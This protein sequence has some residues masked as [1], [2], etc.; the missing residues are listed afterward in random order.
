M[1]EYELTGNE[2]ALFWVLSALFVLG[3]WLAQPH[4]PHRRVTIFRY[5]ISEH[6]LRIVTRIRRRRKSHPHPSHAP[7]WRG[8]G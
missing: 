8:S 6:H 2:D 4:H 1:N 7:S 3:F 5:W